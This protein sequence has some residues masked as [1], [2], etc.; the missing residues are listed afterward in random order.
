MGIGGRLLRSLAAVNFL[1]AG[2]CVGA[3]GES[4][5]YFHQVGLDLRRF[6]GKIALAGLDGIRSGPL[7]YAGEKIFLKSG[8]LRSRKRGNWSWRF[9][10]VGGLE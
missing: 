7:V 4:F 3:G 9:R 10:D 8:W 1:I 6:K 5:F 2:D